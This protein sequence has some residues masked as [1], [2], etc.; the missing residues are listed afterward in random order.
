[1]AT[2]NLTTGKALE[3]ALT[4][5][6]IP[7][8]KEK[9][10]YPLGSDELGTFGAQMADL[11]CDDATVTALNA[12]VDGVLGFVEDAAEGAE[13]FNDK[14]I[15][16]YGVDENGGLAGIGMPMVKSSADGEL[17][18]TIGDNSVVVTQA[19]DGQFTL[20]A[21]TG[22]L[23]TEAGDK[24]TAFR[25]RLS[26]KGSGDRYLVKVQVREGVEEDAILDAVEAGESI[27]AHLKV[28][29]QSGEAK[30]MA[31]LELGCYDVVGVKELKGAEGRPSWFILQLAGGIDV[32]S[33][34]KTDTTLRSGLNI[35][36]IRSKG[37][38]VLLQITGKKPF[39]ENKVQVDCGLVVLPPDR[40][41][42]KLA[43][44]AA[45]GAE[46]AMAAP[47]AKRAEP[48]KAAAAPAAA[49]A[50]PAAKAA[51]ARKSKAAAVAVAEP[52]GADTEVSLDF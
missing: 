23:E 51:A 46:A 12:G 39:G 34:T 42:K 14:S 10:W 27:A 28:V 47:A 38:H 49:A 16:R 1:M 41:A 36:F 30:N 45:A 37:N 40:A 15:L 13:G 6:D 52:D 17:V 29:G 35:E 7:G 11:G 25:L 44:T 48:A 20:G 22:R 9:G 31:D 50:N 19:D 32:K 18:C 33:R 3:P 8:D 43:A 24:Y 26:S 4:T 2:L 5:L 21:L